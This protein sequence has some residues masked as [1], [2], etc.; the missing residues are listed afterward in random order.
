MIAVE[1]SDGKAGVSMHRAAANAPRI[2]TPNESSAAT[3]RR[4]YECGHAFDRAILRTL[5]SAERWINT[6]VAVRGR[7]GVRCRQSARGWGKTS[8]LSCLASAR[9]PR[10]SAIAL[11]DTFL[12]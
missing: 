6:D 11:V 1:G 7:D 4:G 12:T 5:G 8:R 2:P 10:R 3:V 9:Q